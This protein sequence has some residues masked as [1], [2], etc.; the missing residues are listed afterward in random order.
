MHFNAVIGQKMKVGVAGKT[1]QMVEPLTG[2][3]LEIVALVAALPYS[4]HIYT[5]GIVSAKE[6][7]RHRYYRNEERRVSCR[8]LLFLMN[9]WNDGRPRRPRITMFVSTT[10]TTSVDQAYLRKEVLIQASAAMVKIFSK[11]GGYL[12]MDQSYCKEPVVCRSEPSSGELQENFRME[13]Y[14]HH[15]EEYDHWPHTA[16]A[17]KRILARRKLEVQA[18]QIRQGVLSFARKYSKL[19]KKPAVRLRKWER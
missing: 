11:K 18:Y 15:S 6:P 14:I 12:R 2:E 3:V 7:H 5:E 1:F 8:C 10:L 17:V 9:I 19:W 16:E 13:R 4:R